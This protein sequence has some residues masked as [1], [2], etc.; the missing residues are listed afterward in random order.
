MGRHQAV[1]HDDWSRCCRLVAQHFFNKEAWAGADIAVHAAQ[2]F[3]Q[4]THAD[5][6]ATGEHKQHRKQHE[7][8]ITGP[9]GAEGQATSTVTVSNLRRWLKRI[10]CIAR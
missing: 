7:Q 5:E 10:A 3:A 4:K 8:A 9:V 1:D 2:V 6:L